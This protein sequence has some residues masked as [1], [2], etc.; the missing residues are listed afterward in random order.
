M[1][2]PKAKTILIAIYL[3]LDAVL[4]YP[5]LTDPARR[6][7]SVRLVSAEELV[8]AKEEALSSGVDVACPIP[9]RAP[10]MPMLVLSKA[11]IDRSGFLDMLEGAPGREVEGRLVYEG[12]NRRLTVYE[13]GVIV[14]EDLA[15]ISRPKAGG[16][17]AEFGRD[18]AVEAACQFWQE[19][20]GLPS[21]S[22]L[23][24]VVPD[25]ARGA[26][27]VSFL[28]QFQGIPLFGSRR[29]VLLNREGIQMAVASWFDVIGFR[30]EAAPIITAAEAL[31]AVCRERSDAA[32]SL[33]VRGIS[34]GYYSEAYNAQRWEAAPAWRFSLEDGSNLYVNAYTGTLEG[35]GLRTR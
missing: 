19:N 14:Y 8:R 5:L 2:W 7:E 17:P 13:N 6:A 35:G 11:E 28:Q 27:G 18:E 21:D 16:L 12:R 31:R 34:L 9:E 25:E 3:V 10:A 29:Y 23:D 33:V 32:V 1:D 30:R 20:T 22:A 26:Y 15:A 4:A 24:T